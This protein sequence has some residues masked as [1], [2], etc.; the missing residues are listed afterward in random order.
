[1]ASVADAPDDRAAPVLAFGPDDRSHVRQYTFGLGYNLDVN[2]KGSLGLAIQKSDYRKETRF[3]DPLLLP[4]ESHDK[5]VLFSVNATVALFSGLSAYGGYVRGLEESAVAPD[6]A[7][8]RNEAPPA[9]PSA[10]LAKSG[11]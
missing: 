2:G 5:P 6:I 1:M 7:S 8:N 3:A 9:V 10:P 11:R 4:A